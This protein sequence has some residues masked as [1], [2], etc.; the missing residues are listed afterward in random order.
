MRTN[1][2]AWSNSKPAFLLP[3]AESSRVKALRFHGATDEVREALRPIP[4]IIRRLYRDRGRD[5][6][7]RESHRR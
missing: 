4:Q 1:E 3:E 5:E 6:P 2:R 7:D